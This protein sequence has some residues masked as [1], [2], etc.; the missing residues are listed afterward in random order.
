M[1][2]N[3]PPENMIQIIIFTGLCEN[4]VLAG[5]MVFG[6]GMHV[7]DSSNNHVKPINVNIRNNFHHVYLKL[8]KFLLQYKNC[9]CSLTND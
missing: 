9:P 1:L 5:N 6:G 4:D 2:E 3:N 8:C 7:I